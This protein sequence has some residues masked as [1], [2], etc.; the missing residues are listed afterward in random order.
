MNA[1]GYI[2]KTTNLIDKMFYIGQKKGEFNPNYFGSSIHVDRSIEKHGKDNFKLEIIICA[3]DKQKLNELEKLYIKEY[4]EKFGRDMMYN[5]ADGGDGG[6]IYEIHPL[7][8][9]HHSIKTIEKISKANLGKKRSQETIERI[10]IAKQGCIIGPPSV[11]AKMNM[12]LAKK[13]IKLSPEHC[14]NLS[15]VMTGKKRGRYNKE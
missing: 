15:L 12:S 5:I 11:E 7:L 6:R 14:K 10:R 13:G 3:E 9:K 2:Y 4:R 1:Y 8:G